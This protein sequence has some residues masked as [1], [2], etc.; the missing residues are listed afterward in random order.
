MF[1]KQ[2][3]LY[4]FLFFACS[5]GLAWLFLN[6]AEDPL[7]NRT[8]CLFRNVTTIPCPSCGTTRS[9]W[10]VLQGEFI[11]ALNYNPLGYIVLPVMVITPL[12]IIFDLINAKNSLFIF[13]HR[14]ESVLKMKKW[15]I[16][17]MGLIVLNW[18]WNLYKYVS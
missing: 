10:A 1:Q 13:Y 15:F 3:N 4:L 2:R 12:W 6:H 11:E 5:A 7:N 16:L 8:F 18:I 14:V 17:F 9:V